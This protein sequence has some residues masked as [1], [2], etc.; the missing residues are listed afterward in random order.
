[1]TLGF[2]S[3]QIVV[4]LQL[5][6][7]LGESIV[8]GTFDLKFAVTLDVNHDEQE[9]DRSECGGTLR[10]AVI[11]ADISTIH[12]A[13]GQEWKSVFALNVVDGCMPSDLGAGTTAEIEE[14]RR[15]LYV[16]M[17]RARMICTWSRPSAFSLTASTRKATAMF[18]PPG[19]GSFR[20]G[21]LACLRG[22][23]GLPPCS[24]PLRD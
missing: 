9:G 18:M 8:A 5:H 23:C 17:T 22:R 3:N 15:L 16:A 6:S 1:M 20:T 19:R 7:L 21:C 24:A 12:S 13:R 4:Q 14:E 10:L 2:L 11:D